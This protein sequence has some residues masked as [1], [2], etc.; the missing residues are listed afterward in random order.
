MLAYVWIVTG[1]F[2]VG[3]PYL[4]RDQIAWLLKSNSR[5]MAACIGGVAYGAAVII[6]AL[7]FFQQQS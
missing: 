2:W 4:M 6:S 3:M 1:I 7:L 5:W